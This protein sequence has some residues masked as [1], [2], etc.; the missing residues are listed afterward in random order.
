ML[1]PLL[2]N[3]VF[4]SHTNRCPPKVQRVYGYSGRVV[5]RQGTADVN[6]I[7]AG[8]GLRLPCGVGK[9]VRR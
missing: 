9:A 6:G 3:I 8:C 4:C 2:L 5:A 1:F 7:G